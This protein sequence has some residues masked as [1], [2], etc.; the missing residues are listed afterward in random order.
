[1]LGRIDSEGAYANLVLGHELERS[2][3]E[4][5][6]RAF[7]TELVYGVTRL[8]RRLDHLVDPYLLRPVDPP[9]RA[10]LRL[11]AYQLHELGTPPHA[12]VSATVDAVGAN[13]ARGLVNAV[14]RRVA[15]AAAGTTWPS[16][17]V[18]LSYPDWIVDRLTADLG[19]DDASAAL[20]AMNDAATV[21]ERDDGYVQDRA[22]QLVAELAAEGLDAG[23]VA[24][25]LCA[26][27]GGKA[28]AMAASG[29]V[30]VAADLRPKRVG[31][32]RENA[33]RLGLD[34]VLPLVAD[35]TAPPFRAGAFAA[36]LVDAPCSGLGTLRR[37]ADARWRIDEAAPER[38]A[39]LQRRLLAAAADLVA[40]GGLLT[41]SVCTLTEVEGPGVAASLDWTP[42]PAPSD[43]PWREW[44]P[45]ALLL[46]QAEGTDGMFVARWRRPPNL[47]DLVPAA[48]TSK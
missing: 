32:V 37:R 11:G 28:T 16:E 25:D 27:P 6:D 29:G 45:G 26:A 41:Y 23:S 33:R 30:V 31:L 34:A 44:G 9:V 40:P 43:P 2:G 22:S 21:T 10:A 15:G 4:Q 19:A 35:G 8:Q 14:L 36:V 1:V 3:L 17:A 7:V 48:A 42:E 12:A 38:L 18:R 5:R 20:D 24:A 39:D 13:K 46:P 47:P